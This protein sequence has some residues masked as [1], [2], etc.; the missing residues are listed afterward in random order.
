MGVDINEPISRKV[1]ELTPEFNATKAL[2]HKFDWDKFFDNFNG[3][4]DEVALVFVQG[5]REK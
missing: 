2:F 3:C 5:F 1:F 4:N